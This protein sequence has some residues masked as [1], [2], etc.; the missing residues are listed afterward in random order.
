MD[1]LIKPIDPIECPFCSSK[2]APRLYGFTEQGED[3]HYHHKYTVR[4]L[5]CG[6]HGPRKEEGPHAIAAWNNRRGAETLAVGHPEHFEQDANDL[7]KVP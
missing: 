5:N 4:C 2:Y 6:A 1:E 7:D 3:G